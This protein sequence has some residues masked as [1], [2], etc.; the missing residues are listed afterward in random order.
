MKLICIGYVYSLTPRI[1]VGDPKR[2][3][4]ILSVPFF[5]NI[6]LDSCRDFAGK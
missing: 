1:L 4:E 3:M 5:G 2:T 6:L